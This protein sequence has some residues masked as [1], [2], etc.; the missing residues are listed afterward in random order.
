MNIP[1]FGIYEYPDT[2]HN[3]I[4]ALLNNDPTYYVDSFNRSAVRK[5]ISDFYK[6]YKEQ[7]CN[8]IFV[9]LDEK[10]YGYALTLAYE[11]LGRWKYDL[12]DTKSNNNKRLKFNYSSG[13]YDLGYVYDESTAEFIVNRKWVSV[14]EVK[15]VFSLL[16]KYDCEY[17][18]N[19]PKNFTQA[20]I[21]FNNE[22]YCKY[23]NNYHNIYVNESIKDNAKTI[24]ILR[25]ISLDRFFTFSP[26]MLMI[27]DSNHT[28]N[29]IKDDDYSILTP[30]KLKT[31]EKSYVKMLMHH[32]SFDS[33]LIN[34]GKC[35]T[36]IK[37]YKPKYGPGE[38][39]YDNLIEYKSL[40]KKYDEIELKC[41]EIV[42][43]DFIAKGVD[44][45]SLKGCPKIVN[46]NFIVNNNNLK[47]FEGLPEHIGGYL[48][49]SNN[50][51]TDAAWEYAKENMTIDF[52]GYR[53]HHNMFNKYRKELY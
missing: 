22:S 19:F 7:I 49:I 2:R 20:K 23:Y 21:I 15:K 45:A 28:I 13:E 44:L 35:D 14:D 1:E 11:F 17:L 8:G 25:L 9:E 16:T 46:G 50:E 43:G 37:Y 24:E 51:F 31:N 26:N 4:S 42:E 32:L 10:T 52:N 33:P 47:S 53:M 27:I 36:T 29:F 48:D 12:V 39:Y 34:I 30:F 3:I 41:P 6:Y 5:D 18:V 38:E 40:R